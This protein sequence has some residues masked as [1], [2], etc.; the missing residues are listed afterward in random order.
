MNLLQKIMDEAI[1]MPGFPDIIVTRGFASLDYLVFA[2]PV[3]PYP[4]TK[5]RRRNGL[6]KQV[7]PS[8][9]RGDAE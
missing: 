8:Y 2:A 9:L 4:L 1:H 7:R 5:D 6:L 3:A